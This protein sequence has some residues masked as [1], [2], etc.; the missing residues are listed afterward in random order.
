[1]INF[2]NTEGKNT[3]H[4]IAIGEHNQKENGKMEN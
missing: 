2:I 1:M 4:S 3:F